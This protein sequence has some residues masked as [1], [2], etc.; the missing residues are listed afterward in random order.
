MLP[1]LMKVLLVHNRYRRRS[2]EE[3]SIAFQTAALRR[4]G[5]AVVELQR[6]SRDLD[7]ASVWRKAMALPSLFYSTAAARATEAMVR[8]ERPDVAHVHNVWPLLSPSV[9][10][11]LHRLR[12]PIVQTIE[13]YRFLG[14]VA[15]SG[16]LAG[17]RTAYQSVVSA[18]IRLHRRLGTF[19]RCIDHCIHI[20]QAVRET[21]RRHG[22]DAVP[23]T[24]VPNCVDLGRFVPATESGA[25]IVYAGRLAPEKGVAVLLQALTRLPRLP[26]QVV[27]DGPER[28]GLEAFVRR[29]RLANVTF[30]GTLDPDDCFER[31]RGARM[32][33]VPSLWAEPLGMV[34]IEAAAAGVPVIA[35]RVGGL[36][37]VVLD[38]DTGVL[39]DA[40]DAG[41]L[42]KA[43]EELW[44]DDGRVGRMR[45]R[46]R[47][48]AEECFGDD[49]V[50]AALVQAYAA[51]IARAQARR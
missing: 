17:D 4:H 43:I 27:G 29:Q 36:P 32:V 50:C 26:L 16:E 46:A 1:A 48:R 9:Y 14:G 8:R 15:D 3:A 6:D 49:S 24:V 31:I 7:G 21:H 11:A 19:D 13:N 44:N 12:V 33:V 2:G 23:A 18:A 38:G 10:I 20:S 51:A 34:A 28:A 37:E 22:F 41:G 39:V 5:H 30:T 45:R 40:G 25:Y 47:Q 42:A 35:S